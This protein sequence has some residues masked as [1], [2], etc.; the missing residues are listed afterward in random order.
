MRG[1]KVLPGMRGVEIQAGEKAVEGFG[2]AGGERMPEGARLPDFALGMAGAAEPVGGKVRLRT[3]ILGEQPL[4]EVG[5]VLVTA[6]FEGADSGDGQP[7]GS[8]R[9]AGEGVRQP[10]QIGRSFVKRIDG[11]SGILYG[12]GGEGRQRAQPQRFR[13]QRIVGI[14]CGECA[15]DAPPL[16]GHALFRHSSR[17]RQPGLTKADTV[18]KV[19]QHAVDGEAGLCPLF[20]PHPG[21]GDAQP[22]FAGASGMRRFFEKTFE[23]GDSRRVGFGEQIDLPAQ[24]RIDGHVPV[25]QLHERQVGRR[26]WPGL[27][28]APCSSGG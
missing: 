9:A 4:E 23:G 21:A 20:Q 22:G 16:C 5:G 19:G 10:E 1:D 18:G 2:R 24:E 14:S 11:A 13:R 6:A 25:L 17:P 3:G 27:R 7:V 28:P 12:A 26:R 8:T 15:V